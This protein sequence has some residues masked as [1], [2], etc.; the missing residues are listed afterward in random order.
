MSN[1]RVKMAGTPVPK[2][3]VELKIEDGKIVCPKC[4]GSGFRLLG[5]CYDDLCDCCGGYIGLAP[6]DDEA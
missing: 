2:R 5:S 3:E 1:Y 6:N 4:D